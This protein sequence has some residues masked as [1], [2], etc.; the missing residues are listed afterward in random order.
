MFIKEIDLIVN[1][2]TKRTPGPAN[3]TGRYYQTFKEAPWPI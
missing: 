2:L 3:F 1:L